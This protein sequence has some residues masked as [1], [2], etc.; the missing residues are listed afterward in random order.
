LAT[1]IGVSANWSNNRRRFGEEG[2]D[3]LLSYLRPPSNDKEVH[4]TTAKAVKASI[5]DPENSNKLRHAGVVDCLLIMGESKDQD[6]Q[7]AAAVAIRNI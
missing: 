4:A 1:A 7:M 5:D 3:S 6:L 2:A